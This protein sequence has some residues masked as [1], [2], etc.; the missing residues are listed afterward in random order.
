MNRTSSQKI[1]RTF[2]YDSDVIIREHRRLLKSSG[3]ILIPTLDVVALCVRRLTIVRILW[4]F[5][6]DYLRPAAKRQFPTTESPAGSDISVV[7]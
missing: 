1:S 6:I 4:K 5:S 2:T 3:A 7:K